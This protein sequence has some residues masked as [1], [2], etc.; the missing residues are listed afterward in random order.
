MKVLLLI[1]SLI[2][3]LAVGFW[4]QK[5]PVG[6]G[7]TSV[8]AKD[9]VSLPEVQVAK[10]MRQD[11]AATLRLPANISPLQQTTLFA[12]VSGYLKSVAADKG[13]F[14][15]IAGRARQ[16]SG[17]SGRRTQLRHETAAPCQLAE[18]WS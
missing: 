5:P 7:N 14:I 9:S 2:A 3:L 13:E 1:V 15:V 6:G 16:R 8:S 18:R 12:K 11:V 10:P 4:V 17:T